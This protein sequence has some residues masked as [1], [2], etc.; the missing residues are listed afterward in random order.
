MLQ[1]NVAVHLILT[2]SVVILENFV[3]TVI[4]VIFAM[5][6]IAAAI[7]VFIFIRKQ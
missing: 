4:G 7:G 1:Y 6:A 5:L 2:L 3:G